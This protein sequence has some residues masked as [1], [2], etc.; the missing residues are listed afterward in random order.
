MPPSCG[1]AHT[2]PPPRRRRRLLLLRA[3]D[4]RAHAGNACRPSHQPRD[5]RP[6]SN[7]SRKTQRCT[8]RAARRVDPSRTT[9]P[10]GARVP[11][12]RGTAC[13][14]SE[15][16]CEGPRQRSNPVTYSHTPYLHTTKDIAGTKQRGSTSACADLER[17]ST[18]QI[19]QNLKVGSVMACRVSACEC[20]FFERVEG[21]ADCNFCQHKEEMHGSVHAAAA[22]PTPAAAAPLMCLTCGVNPRPVVRG[23]VVGPPARVG[24]QQHTRVLCEMSGSRRISARGSASRG[25][26]GFAGKA[27]WASARMGAFVP[28]CARL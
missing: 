27:L 20:E 14:T 16:C 17:V 25:P 11:R 22:A 1:I 15:R 13:R 12:Q 4:P 26:A 19:F 9:T 5:C 8:R 2:A 10:R 6:C 7:C 18:R 23:C 21:V 28:A 24:G 3:G